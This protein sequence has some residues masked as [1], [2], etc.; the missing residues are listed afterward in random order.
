IGDNAGV[1][2]SDAYRS[3][4]IGFESGAESVYANYSNFFGYFAGSG[5][6]QDQVGLP[7]SILPPIPGI[8]SSEIIFGS[9]FIGFSA[10]AGATDA[11]G[12]NFIGFGAG[13]GAADAHLSNFIGFGAGG[14]A[15]Y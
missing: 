11:W 13:I 3:N 7:A 4:F 14:Y 12:S 5:V 1:F 6:A 9:N 8:D 15:I 10:G 2:A